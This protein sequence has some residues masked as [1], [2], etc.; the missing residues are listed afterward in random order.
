MKIAVIQTAFPGDV[1]LSLPLYEALKDLYP[2]SR[3][4]AVVRPESVCLL[5]SNP[6]INE[7]IPFDKYGADSG[8]AGLFR[9][10]SKLKGYDQAVIVQ[11]HLRSALLPILA[12]IPRRIGHNNSRAHLLY[13][14][15]IPYRD[16]VHEV[17]RCL[18]LVGV[19]ND[20]KK[21]SPKIYL[22]EKSITEADR[23]LSE[24]GLTSAFIVVAP[25]SVWATKRYVHFPKLI[26]LLHEKFNIPIVM[27]GGQDDLPLSIEISKACA[28]QPINLTGKT[29]LLLSAAIISKARLAITNDS[30]PSHI[31]A[32]VGT[33]VVAI[34]GPTV[35]SFGFAPYSQK[36]AVVDIGNLYCRP[37]THHGSKECPQGHFRCMK[38]LLPEKIVEAAA[39]IFIVGQ[40]SPEF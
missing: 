26:D 36:S 5:K 30:A 1:I 37:C 31:A 29:D 28:H 40:N 6:F 12:R 38:E 33:P 35:P 23:L 13:T 20:G 39:L 24:S 8:P 10:A 9:I 19:N 32:A 17:Q 14:A 11:R 21:Y 25:G 15:K 16:N 7:I 34:F 27:L 2:N 3:L 22:D 4:A 18:D